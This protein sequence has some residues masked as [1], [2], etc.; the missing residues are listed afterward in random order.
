M[1]FN[2]FAEFVHGKKYRERGLPCQDFAATLEFGDVQ[3]IAVADGH[4]GKDYFRSDTGAQLAVETAFE[5]LEQIY[6][7]V[8]NV[9]KIFDDRGIRNFELSIVEGW[10]EKVLA[11]WYQRLDSRDNEVRWQTVS[12]KYKARFTS[13]DENIRKH[14]IPVA[15]GTTLICAVSIGTQVL[16]VQ[17]GDGSCVVLR[18]DGDWEVPVPPDKANFANVTTSLCDEDAFEKFRHIVLNCDGNSP[19]AIFL[20]SD[21]LDDCYPL[22]DNEKHLFKFYRETVIN[23]LLDD[24]FDAT[25]AGLREDILPYMT[26]RGSNDDISLAWLVAEDLDLLKATVN[27]PQVQSPVEPQTQSTVNVPQTQSVNVPQTQSTVT[28]QIQTVIEPQVQSTIEPQT[29]STVAPQTQ[30]TV[31]P[32][33]QSTFTPQAQSTVASQ[34][35][36]TIEPQVQPT[37]KLTS[38]MVKP[39][40][41]VSPV[42]KAQNITDLPPTVIPAKIDRKEPRQ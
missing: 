22:F 24:G 5:L 9:E 21:G 14:Y 11:D 18:R 37:Q 8:G 40:P 27:E 19:V 29:Q 41:K 3:A 38:P 32:Q 16:I 31:A 15:Y 30:S 25:A 42:L 39:P 34:A 28:P 2:L 4:G 12:D 20:S 17:I 1:K 26:E 7:D 23:G 35:Q 13:D 10:R 33:A 6:N 36:S